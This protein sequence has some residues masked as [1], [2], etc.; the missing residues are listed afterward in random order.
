MIHRRTLVLGAAAVS[1][2][3][4]SG[5]AQAGVRGP[6]VG[7]VTLDTL[8]TPLPRPYDDQAGAAAVD[9]RLKAA[10]RRAGR[11]RKRVIVDLGGNWCG[12]CRALAAVMA[13]PSVK[14]FVEANFEVVPVSV[15]SAKGLT[16]KNIHVLKRFKIKDVD[17]VP[18]LIVAEPNGRVL[19]SSSDVTDD[20]H[21]T[22]QQ[23]VDWLAQWAR[24]KA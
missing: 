17:G 8:P 20:N 3:T 15:S 10:F 23:M 1:A 4:A 9:A 11:T 21:Q 14:P 16:D 22:P 24:S 2:L 18:W 12:W 5:T 6:S 7:G 19:S 13:L